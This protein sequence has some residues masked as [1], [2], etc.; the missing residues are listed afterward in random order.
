[1]G[2]IAINNNTKEVY[3][4][5][6]ANK[7]ANL[8]GCNP[9]TITKKLK[10]PHQWREFKHYSIAKTFDLSNFDRGSDI[11]AVFNGKKLI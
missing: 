2:F 9:T 7:I 5:K 3:F 1:M 10:K 4:S 8:V 11:K 6:G